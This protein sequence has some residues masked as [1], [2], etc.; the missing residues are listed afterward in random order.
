MEL[1]KQKESTRKKR[2]CNVCQKEVKNMKEHMMTHTGEK[3][4]SC[5]ICKKNFAQPHIVKKHMVIHGTEKKQTRL[6]IAHAEPLKL[7]LCVS[8]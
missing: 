3:P 5:S 1:S 7:P 2:R 4:Y 8:L 6:E